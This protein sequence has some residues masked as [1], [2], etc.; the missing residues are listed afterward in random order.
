MEVVSFQWPVPADYGGV[1]DVY[2]KIRALRHEGEEVRLHS[3]TYGSRALPDLSLSPATAT[4]LYRRNTAPHRLL[5][6]EPYIVSSRKSEELFRA[7]AALPAGTPVIFEG[8]HTCAP[9]AL[10][11]LKDKIK[12]VR[13]H[14]VEHDYYTQLARNSSGLK[15]LY[16]L[17]EA[18]KLR[19]F[20]KILR[21]ADIILAI[22]E[23]DARYFSR[24]YPQARTI[25]ITCFYDDADLERP[26]PEPLNHGYVAGR[27]QTGRSKVGEGPYALYHGNLAVEEN[28]EAVRYIMTKLSAAFSPEFPLVV[29]GR[30][31]GDALRN[32]IEEAPNVTLIDNPDSGTMRRLVENAT[33]TLLITNQN[34]GIKL[35]L[36][37][38][39]S[40]ARGAVLATE[41]MVG[42]E[43]LRPLLKIADNAEAQM[44]IIEESRGNPPVAG[45]LERR[46]EVLRSHF[47]NR[48][49]ARKILEAVR[50]KRDS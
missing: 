46:R 36:L 47:S 8:L 28:V 1:I 39:L 22:S 27:S 45:E 48:A 34:T 24:H 31:C 44:R 11:E 41:A 33:V 12:I 14:N 15:K 49:N 18:R 37:E 10:P 6:G 20:E 26:A 43:L 7:L 17:A 16:F 2:H 9:L 19:R 21:H 50:E 42:N 32:E 25:H 3:Y 30:G 38:T 4:A 29:A 5:T 40:K 35:K 13:A 23:E